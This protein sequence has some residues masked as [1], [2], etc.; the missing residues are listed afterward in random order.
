MKPF[1]TSALLILLAIGCKETI[2]EHTTDD[3][4]FHNDLLHGDLVGRV[5]QTDS[6]ASVKV[7][8]LT[9]VDSTQISTSDGSFVFRDL[10][11]GNYDLTISSDNY[12]TY[13]RQIEVKGGTITYA[14]EILLSTTPDLV[15]TYYPE[16]G[17]EIVHDWRYGRIAISIYF[18]KPMDRVSVEK[19]FSTNPPS[20]GIFYWGT[21]TYAPYN[22]LYSYAGYARPELGATITTY[23]KV[24]AMTYVMAQKDSYV[25][26]NYTVTLS[27]AVKDTAG[28]H[29][30]FPLVFSFRTVQSYYTQYGIITNPVH[31]DVSVEPMSTGGIHVTFPRRMNYASTEAATTITPAIS[32]VF[33]WPQENEMLIYPGGP[34]LSDTTITV[35]IDGTAQDKDGTALGT[36]FTFSFRTAP[37]RL[38]YTYP[39]NADVFVSSS[40]K[41]TLSFNSFVIK[42][43]VETAFS[44]SP[45][46]GGSFAYDGY[47]GYESRNRIVFTPS[48]QLAAGTKYTVTISTAAKDLYATP[49]KKPHS[50][51]FVVMPN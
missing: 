39:A 43:S 4:I 15:S 27:T 30:R 21:Y 19:A 34:L 40:A 42:S 17:A 7:S 5:V 23:S 35:T 9:S 13:K 36:A 51:S 41:I 1:I 46:I 29:L 25:D 20:E 44:I 18:E 32:K 24:R 33:L 14:G 3:K 28:N 11:A 38:S 47:P 16:N 22:T 31:G 50:F 8:Q 45:A 48:Q 6:R 10:R 12:R 37:F 49:M 2:I 26:T